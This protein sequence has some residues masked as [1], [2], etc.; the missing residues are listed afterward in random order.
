VEGADTS[1][2]AVYDNDAQ[3]EDVGFQCGGDNTTVDLTITEDVVYLGFGFDIYLDTSSVNLDLDLQIGISG[4]LI[5]TCPGSYQVTTYGWDTVI[6]SGD[7][8]T[9][10]S[11]GGPATPKLLDGTILTDEIT[12]VLRD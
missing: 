2:T 9:L 6:V 5:I 8:R 3:L 11:D 10:M 1:I 4:T 12:A 7:S